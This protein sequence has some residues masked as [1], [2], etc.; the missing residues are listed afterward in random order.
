[1]T[2]QEKIDLGVKMFLEGQ[3][4]I[5]DISKQLKFQSTV[6]I[7]NKLKML[8]YYGIGS[9]LK[10]VLALTNA[11]HE[12][13]ENI[14]NKPSL[15]KISKKYGTYPQTLSRVLKQN[16]YSVINYHNRTKFNEH[17]FD[18]IDTEE[19]AYWLGF[20]YADGYISSA[21]KQGINDHHFELSLKNADKQHLIKFNKFMQHE[22]PNHVKTNIVTTTMVPGKTFL[23]CRWAVNNRHLWETLNNYGCTPR[24]SLTLKFPDISIFKNKK[25]IKDFI[26]GYWDGDGCISN[27]DKGKRMMCISVLG[28]QD[29]LTKLRDNLPLK[30][31]CGV[32]GKNDLGVKVLTIHGKNA[33]FIT[34]YLY[35]GAKIY[36]ERKYKK[37]K[38]YCRIYEESYIVLQVK[39]G[40]V[41]LI[42]N[43][44]LNEETKQ[45]SSV[46]SVGVEPEKSE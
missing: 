23:R 40:R 11:V 4:T 36:L 9:P 42:D 30:A 38:N 41:K 39:N 1:M 34:Y 46:Q 21:N 10:T 32:F 18:S 17:I 3:G 20:I 15:S 26:R 37:Y 22:D 12:Y 7:S 35:E 45:S 43:S 16:G 31:H 19:K 25:L 24:K 27:Q 13:I 6:P 14:N 28:T 33:F 8:G 44:V 29:F 5:M 2:E